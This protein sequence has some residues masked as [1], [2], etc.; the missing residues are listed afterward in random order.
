VS[1][2]ELRRAVRQQQHHHP[3]THHLSSN[4]IAY[5]VE[6]VEPIDVGGG[7]S[8]SGL[9]TYVVDGH[10]MLHDGPALLY[11]SSGDYALPQS[12]PPASTNDAQLM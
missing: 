8:N 5:A 9:N 11:T 3:V 1:E 10:S 7:G 4:N 12:A 2:A 6:G